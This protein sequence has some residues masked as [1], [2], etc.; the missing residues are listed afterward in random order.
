MVTKVVISREVPS[1]SSVTVLSAHFE[2]RSANQGEIKNG[3]VE[4]AGSSPPS[5]P[6]PQEDPVCLLVRPKVRGRKKVV[7]GLEIPRSGGN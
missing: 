1:K 2:V 7:T 3:K 6:S 5:G 4:A